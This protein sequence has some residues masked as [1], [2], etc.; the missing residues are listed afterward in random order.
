MGSPF[1]L[2]T[3]PAAGQDP[4]S[5]T[6]RNKINWLREVLVT[7][8]VNA[9][10]DSAGVTLK[11]NIPWLP[12]D[13]AIAA[14]SGTRGQGWIP[15]DGSQISRASFPALFA[16]I[17]TTWGAG[18]GSTTF[19]VPWFDGKTLVMSGTGSGLTSRSVGQTGGL[20]NSTL[21]THT[22]N[23]FD[24]GHAHGSASYL[25]VAGASIAV[26]GPGNVSAVNPEIAV[27]NIGIFSSGSSPIGTNMMPFAVCRAWIKT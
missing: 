10:D 11:E 7:L 5:A 27:T 21:P 1:G 2:T 9:A 18:N 26:S 17:G 8:L 15:C 4:T 16:K 19:N 25:K 20:E 3:D 14:H 13:I 24:P 23:I 12:G 22:H 6:V